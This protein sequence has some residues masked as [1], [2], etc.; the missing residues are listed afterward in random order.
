[1]GEIKQ[2]V[3]A[4]GWYA[5]FEQ[6]DGGVNFAKLA[7]WG[8]TK[9][10]EIVGVEVTPHRHEN[11]AEAKNFKG[12]YTSEQMKVVLESRS[13]GETPVSAPLNWVAEYSA[14]QEAFNIGSLKQILEKNAQKI[15]KKQ[16]NG[17]QIFA[18]CRTS[19]E[20]HAF[21]E[22]MK[23]IQ[24]KAEKSES[25]AKSKVERRK[26]PVFGQSEEH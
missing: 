14:E 18:I 25:K 6:E 10:G 2:I 24:K 12:Y 23:R 5:A 15:A 22:A 21:C 8:L 3:P 17:Y 4:N 7:V 20:A 9:N 19:I 11:V 1:M 13:G 26:I 16:N